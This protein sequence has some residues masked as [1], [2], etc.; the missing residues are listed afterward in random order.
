MQSAKIDEERLIIQMFREVYD[1]FPKGKIIKSESPDFILKEP[2]KKK[3]GIELTRLNNGN[4]EIY[5]PNKVLSKEAYLVDYTRKKLRKKSRLP[6]YVKFLFNKNEIEKEDIELYG[7]FL[8]LYIYKVV[9]SLD[10]SRQ[11]IF[12]IGEKLP[13][14]IDSLIIIYNPNFNTSFWSPAN[15][16]LIYDLSKEI[17][18][19][20]IQLKEEKLKFYHSKKYD[21]YWLLITTLQLNP[22][23][24][25][26]INNKISKWEF[27]SG[28][29][30]V[31]LFELVENRFY[32]L[33]L[34]R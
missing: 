6:L 15:T 3:T 28:F 21:R 2:R 32:K 11:H 5:S 33:N 34:S 1:D 16:L 8:S 18:G 27:R 10:R 9:Q 20:T 7:D 19:K 24:N 12:H 29:E 23:K 4:S 26:N 13:D 31:F 22:G 30:K 14:I 17:L 25:F